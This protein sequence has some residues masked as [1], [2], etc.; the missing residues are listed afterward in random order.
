MG[1]EDYI[2]ARSDQYHPSSTRDDRI[3]SPRQQQKVQ[4]NDKFVLGSGFPPSRFMRPLPLP[5][6]EPLPP[7][8]QQNDLYLAQQ[9]PEK[10]IF[11]TD[12]ENVDDSTI[13]VTSVGDIEAQDH[14]HG[15]GGLFGHD[16]IS[17]DWDASELSSESGHTQHEDQMEVTTT[18]NR[19]RKS[20]LPSALDSG[21]TT[22]ADEYDSQPFDWILQSEATHRP[23]SANNNKSK[24]NSVD[25]PNASRIPRA[26][27]RLSLQRSDSDPGARPRSRMATEKEATATNNTRTVQLPNRP[28]PGYRRMSTFPQS[29]TTTPNNR[30]NFKSE[31]P[32]ERLIQQ[33]SPTRK[34]SGPRPQPG[35]RDST[36]PRKTGQARRKLELSSSRVARDTLDTTDE[37]EDD[38]G[39]EGAD[40]DDDTTQGSLSSIIPES[41]S[42]ITQRKISVSTISD[43][44]HLPNLTSDYP[45]EI[46]QQMD[47]TELEQESF[48]HIPNS[49]TTNSP[50]ITNS[51]PHKKPPPPPSPPP[52]APA[53]PV[54]PPEPTAPASEKLDYA[55]NALSSAPSKRQEYLSSMTITEW[56]DFGDELIGQVGEMLKLIK[57]SR[58]SRRRTTALFEAE[59]R[60]RHDET[61]HQSADL[62]RKFAEMKQGGLG[63][64][65]GLKPGV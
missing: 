4:V 62:D 29:L 42:D 54:S 30:F 48:D 5:F 24:R 59:I 8:Q 27:S 25:K 21:K 35:R 45:D 49:L 15:R 39:D 57:E 14:A 17:Q 36:S 13:T 16:V 52:R 31:R 19:R 63:V 47:F 6:V 12:V 28:G 23:A 61:Q 11:D 41:L 58:Q 1:L 55:L 26:K 38:D 34:V 51:T 40:K 37:E 9:Q 32:Y 44:H 22:Y 18:T 56:E 2:R 20:T 64:L 3:L 43:K 33:Q 46:L 60:R 50:L 53:P 65:R 10:S 7:L